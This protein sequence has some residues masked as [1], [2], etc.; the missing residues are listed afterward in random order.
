MIAASSILAALSPIRG[1]V[2]TNLPVHRIE[3]HATIAD[4]NLQPIAAVLQLMRPAWT[5]WRLSGDNR[6]ARMNESGGGRYWPYYESYAH[7]AACARF[8]LATQNKEG[9][10]PGGTALKKLPA[11]LG[12][13]DS[14]ADSTHLTLLEPRSSLRGAPR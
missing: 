7:A 12:E 10:P 5:G 4:M 9:L 2:S 1:S 13:G 11:R 6:T 14:G 8:R 3:P